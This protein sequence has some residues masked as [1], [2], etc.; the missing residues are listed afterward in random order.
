VTIL[1][2]A[3][4]YCHGDCEWDEDEKE[5]VCIQAGHRFS[6]EEMLRIKWEVQEKELGARIEGPG[7]EGRY[8]NTAYS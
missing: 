8:E 2:K 4:L 7:K 3:C 6:R 5:W 1:F